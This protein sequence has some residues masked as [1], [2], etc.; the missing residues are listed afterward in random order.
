MQWYNYLTFINTGL[1]VIMVIL[2]ILACLKYLL[3]K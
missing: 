2:V 1:N 3:K